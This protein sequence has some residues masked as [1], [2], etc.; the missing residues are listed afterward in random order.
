MPV[1]SVSLRQPLPLGIAEPAEQ[2]LHIIGKLDMC[3]PVHELHVAFKI[4][5]VYDC[6]TKLTLC[7][8]VANLLAFGF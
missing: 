2:M 1:P 3:K 8:P 5:C 7:G 6:I 4:P